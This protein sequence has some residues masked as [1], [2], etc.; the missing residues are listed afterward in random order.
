[1]KFRRPRDPT[2]RRKLGREWRRGRWEKLEAS[3]Y[4]DF[5][6]PRTGNRFRPVPRETLFPGLCGSLLVKL[7][8]G[9]RQLRVAVCQLDVLLFG[10][11]LVAQLVVG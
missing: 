7:L 9:R 5:P 3:Y 8:A 11:I 2:D 4:V 1:V 10:W 6:V